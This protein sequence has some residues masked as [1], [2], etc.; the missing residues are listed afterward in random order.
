MHDLEQILSKLAE[1]STETI[2]N[3]DDIERLRSEG[4]PFEVKA[5]LPPEHAIARLFRDRQE[6]AVQLVRMFPLGLPPGTPSV[7]SLYKEILECILFGV[8]GAAI[9]LCGILI[10][11]ALKYASYIVEVGGFA[12]FDP[13]RWDRF[14]KMA[15]EPTIRCAAKNG[16]LTADQEGRLRSFKDGVRNPYNHYNIRK[17]T[18]N[19]ICPR[20]KKLN[21]VT[22][23]VEILDLPAKD[24]PQLQPAAKRW[25]DREQ[26]LVVF[27]FADQVVRDLLGKISSLPTL[28]Q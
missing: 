10:E 16:L 25:V 7:E 1:G 13:G 14:E 15:L 6:R 3:L 9:T 27:G 12:K 8:N 18:A 11:F 4:F 28:T 21:I 24:H 17:I 19:V 5:S 22:K 20:V 23:K 2:A 26:V